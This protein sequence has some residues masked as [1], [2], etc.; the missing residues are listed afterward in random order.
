M[1]DVKVQSYAICQR[2]SKSKSK[3][4]IGQN[5]ELFQL[6]DSCSSEVAVGKCPGE[7]PAFQVSKASRSRLPVNAAGFPAGHHESSTPNKPGR[8]SQITFCEIER[9]A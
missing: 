2:L 6:H 3:K 8:I 7:E 5:G 4:I 1:N 9:K